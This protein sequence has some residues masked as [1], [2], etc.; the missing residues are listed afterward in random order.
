[1]EFGAAD[2]IGQLSPHAR[3]EFQPDDHGVEFLRSAA[4]QFNR[5]GAELVQ[6][7]TSGALGRVEITV[8]EGDLTAA[9]NAPEFGE[10]TECG[11]QGTRSVASIGS[12]GHG[13]G[14]VYQSQCWNRGSQWLATSMPAWAVRVVAA[15]MPLLVARIRPIRFSVLNI[16]CSLIRTS[17][18]LA[19]CHV[20]DA[21][22]CG[23]RDVSGQTLI[24]S[25]RVMGESLYARVS[26]PEQDPVRHPGHRAEVEARL[27][28]DSG[29]V[30]E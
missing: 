17:G 6:Y 14:T 26:L 29:M 11:G 9:D 30:Q 1:V 21:M 16:L 23:P 18:L 15:M 27:A 28:D 13:Y 8:A 2:E 12:P 22:E 19:I 24:L 4:G 10:A 25:N 7:A 3:D 20:S 5:I